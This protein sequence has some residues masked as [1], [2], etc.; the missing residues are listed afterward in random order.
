M[1]SLS[2]FSDSLKPNSDTIFKMV[3]K[4]LICLSVP[5]KNAMLYFTNAVLVSYLLAF[6]HMKSPKVSF[7]KGTSSNFD[8][9]M[10]GSSV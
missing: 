7:D 5:K 9:K 3:Q 8:F 6:D 10:N 4:L 2:L 1:Y